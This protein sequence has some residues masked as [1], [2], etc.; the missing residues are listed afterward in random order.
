MPWTEVKEVGRMLPGDRLISGA[1]LSKLIIQQVDDTEERRKHE[2]NTETWEGTS[3]KPVADYF[4]FDR[5]QFQLS[6]ADMMLLDWWTSLS[7][8]VKCLCLV[9][10][11]LELLIY[12]KAGS[13]AS[14]RFSYWNSKTRC[15]ILAPL[16]G[17]EERINYKCLFLKLNA[18]AN[19]ENVLLTKT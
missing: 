10:F 9:D 17:V 13:G 18:I 8:E 5:W 4:D 6:K 3:T 15:K 16:P 2:N 7:R 19:F 14:I 11:Y 1:N 12:A